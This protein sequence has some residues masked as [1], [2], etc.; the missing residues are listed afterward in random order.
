MAQTRPWKCRRVPSSN[1]TLTLAGVLGGMAWAGL[2]AL[3]RDRFR[4]ACRRLG[5]NSERH[6]TLNTQL[7]RA[8]VTGGQL[9]L[10]L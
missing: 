4:L 6:A 1:S 7:F 2:V 8:P 3:L 5:L 10:E 9:R